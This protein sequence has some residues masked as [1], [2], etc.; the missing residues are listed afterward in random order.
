MANAF[1]AYILAHVISYFRF[2]PS[3]QKLHCLLVFRH[4]HTLRDFFQQLPIPRMETKATEKGT[5]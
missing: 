4:T 3:I 5:L 2:C 1:N